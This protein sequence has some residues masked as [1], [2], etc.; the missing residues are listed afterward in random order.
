MIRATTRAY[1]VAL[2]VAAAA[3]ATAGCDVNVDGGN[4]NVGLASGRASEQ[5]TRTYTLPATGRFELTNINGSITIEASTDG[6]VEVHAER[7]AKSSSDEAARELLKKIEIHE[8]VAADRVALETR[9]PKTWGRDGHEVKYAVKVPKGVR[10]SAKNTN[11]GIDLR[12]L[13]NEV[14]ATTTNGGIKGDDLAGRVE[15]STTNGGV[16]LTLGAVPGTIKAQ[17]VNGGVSLTVPG[18]TKADLSAHVVNGGIHVDDAL[19]FEPVGEQNRRQ[20]E[21][22]LNGG[23]NRIEVSTTNGGVS[24]S[25]K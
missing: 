1:L 10:V 6:K 11:G 19:K 24:V 16:D 4:F 2:S 5:W 23:G 8:E 7:I 12:H 25:S 20:V 13:E 21:G 14:T 17:T 22:R 9:A 3:A 15:V 18:D